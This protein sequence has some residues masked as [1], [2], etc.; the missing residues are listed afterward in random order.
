MQC[1]MRK[2]LPMA[3]AVALAALLAVPVQGN[4]LFPPGPP[5]P[6]M[7]R[8]DQV[9]SSTCINQLPFTIDQPGTY[10][11]CGN[12]SFTDG[13]AGITISASNVSID[14]D[15]SSL[16]GSGPA[17]GISVLPSAQNVTIRNGR[18]N[19]WGGDGIHAPDA[20]NVTIENMRIETCGGHGALL[21]GR[22]GGSIS[23]SSFRGNSGDGVRYVCSSG[24][25]CDDTDPM[26]H[27]G[28][29]RVTSTGNGGSGISS[30]GVALTLEHCVTSDNAAHGIHIEENDS[31]VPVTL[32]MTES[33]SNGN[34]LD[35]V[36][37]VDVPFRMARCVTSLNGSH[38][39][40]QLN[41]EVD[42][43]RRAKNYNSS[44]SN[45][46]KNSFGDGNGGDGIRIE[47]DGLVDVDLDLLN[48]SCGGNQGSGLAVVPVSPGSVGV[49]VGITQSNMSRNG[50]HGIHLANA[51]HDL[52]HV[53][54][55]G[56]ESSGI[57]VEFADLSSDGRRAGYNNS[58]SN[59]ASS[60]TS[61]GNGGAGFAVLLAGEVV[62]DYG[63]TDSSFS[64][65]GAHGVC[66]EEMRKDSTALCPSGT[67]SL[68][69]GSRVFLHLANTQTT[70]NDGNGV[71]MD[72]SEGSD[73]VLVCGKTDHLSSSGNG[74]DGILTDGLTT[75]SFAHV[76]TES[77]GGHGI[78]HRDVA[79][80]ASEQK[81]AIDHSL[82]RSN[83]NGG[84][85]FHYGGGGAGGSITLTSC[86][87]SGNGGR[88][89]AIGDLDGDGFPDFVSLDSCVSS[90]NDQEGIFVESSGEITM[91]RCSS[92]GNGAAGAHLDASSYHVNNSTFSRNDNGG[93]WCWGSGF[94]S[95]SVV[96]NNDNGAMWCWGS[97]R[98]HNNIISDNDGDGITL[99]GVGFVVA[100]NSLSGHREGGGG[101]GGRIALRVTGQGTLVQDNVFVNNDQASS[102]LEDTNPLYSTSSQQENV[103]YSDDD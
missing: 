21:S 40:Y 90:S 30:T 65:N 79:A 22:G 62:L 58:R 13:E 35:G 19:N 71:M 100:G 91:K 28:M 73:K 24:G 7:K 6:T 84:D 69:E 63:I 53:T 82:F 18:L 2:F 97:G 101:G 66:F 67:C 86:R 27:P 92:I 59:K 75:A 48:D 36:H 72:F 11:V 12:L 16:R 41:T 32:R 51:E 57:M 70:A 64:N 43:G 38:G 47:V 26:V 80:R 29:S 20:R 4:P 76:T 3:G 102:L 49:S 99:E 61:S 77:N 45:R 8:L 5:G 52:H 23:S 33:T 93:L 103:L 44:R 14:L 89:V 78:V 46:R 95:N 39:V 34:G 42:E 1:T 96:S 81:R 25:D 55:S 31:P 56:N 9:S 74:G 68:E 60:I 15:G 87:A 85:G 54:S 10:T 50:V 88:G 83:N 17:H 37:C 94:V 98:I